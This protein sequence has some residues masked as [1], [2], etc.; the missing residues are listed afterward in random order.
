MARIR[1]PPNMRNMLDIYK[2]IKQQIKILYDK[3]NRKQKITW[4]E[5][6]FFGLLRFTKQ[7]ECWVSHHSWERTHTLKCSCIFIQNCLQHHLLGCYFACLE[8]FGTRKMCC[9]RRQFCAMHRWA[10]VP[11][12]WAKHG[13]MMMCNRGNGSILSPTPYLIQYHGIFV[14]VP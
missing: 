5:T 3:K 7:Q 2:K 1:T 14:T 13:M 10:F 9:D 6:L 11:L 12:E 8:K 4:S